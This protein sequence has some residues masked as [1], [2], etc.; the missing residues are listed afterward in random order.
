MKNR[1]LGIT[2]LL[3]VLAL[4]LAFMS[5][6]AVEEDTEIVFTNN[7]KIPIIINSD[8]EPK[9]LNLD[10]AKSIFVPTVKSITKKGSAINITAI[11]Y[12]SSLIAGDDSGDRYI[13]LSG[14]VAPGDKKKPKQGV[15][16]GSGS[17][18]FSA[19]TIDTNGEAF[20]ENNRNPASWLKISA[21][22]QDE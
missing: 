22:P 1:I 17:I 15:S 18:V 8:G 4:G 7:T 11:K 21:I 6:P 10:E 3:A 20:G 5:C 13:E 16:L 9:V 2:V 19:Q 12:N 14:S